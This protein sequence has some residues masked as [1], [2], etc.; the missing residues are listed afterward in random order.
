M[1]CWSWCRQSKCAVQMLNSLWPSCISSVSLSL[2]RDACFAGIRCIFPSFTSQGARDPSIPPCNPFLLHQTTSEYP[3]HPLSSTRWSNLALS[4]VDLSCWKLEHRQSIWMKE[5]CNLAA[6]GW[7]AGAPPTLSLGMTTIKTLYCRST[8]V[9][10]LLMF[11]N[12]AIWSKMRTLI[13]R[14]HFLQLLYPIYW[15]P[16]SQT[17]IAGEMLQLAKTRTFIAANISWSTVV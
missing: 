8:N 1:Q 11:A 15:L 10:A 12:F 2:A 17:L 16:K 13:A 4:M 7:R 3:L 9:R 5:Y 14:E 6:G